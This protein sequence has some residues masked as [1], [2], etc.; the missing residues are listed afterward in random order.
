MKTPRIDDPLFY[1]SAQTVAAFALMRFREL[2]G[3]QRMFDA[4]I[5]KAFFHLVC[6][7]YHLCDV[8]LDTGLESVEGHVT[9]GAER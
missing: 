2:Q 7:D 9:P 6:K 4:A 1:A 5:A 3:A 8:D